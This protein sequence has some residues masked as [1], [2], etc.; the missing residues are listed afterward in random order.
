MIELNASEYGA[1]L[2]AQA[3]TGNSIGGALV[4]ANS[5]SK[6]KAKAKKT[7]CIAD[8]IRQGIRDGKA[9]ADI[10]KA[11]QKKHKGC[12]TTMACI[13]WYQSRFKRGLEK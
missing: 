8:T 3:H 7:K 11:V 12:E 4:S 10:L 5:H 9:N 1:L 2:A 13:Y 6:P